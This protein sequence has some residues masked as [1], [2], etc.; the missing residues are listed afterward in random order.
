M[1]QLKDL[2]RIRLGEIA[3]ELGTC[4]LQLCV[5]CSQR[6]TGLEQ[7]GNQ[8]VMIHIVA[9]WRKLKWQPKLRCRI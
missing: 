8:K 6:R 5:R 9:D 2:T 7:T 1:T 3:V 4:E